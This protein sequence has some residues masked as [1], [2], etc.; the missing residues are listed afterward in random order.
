M[1]YCTVSTPRLKY[2]NGSEEGVR[3]ARGTHAGGEDVDGVERRL[4][5]LLVAEDEVDPVRQ[6]LGDGLRLQRLPVD[7]R[8]E[9]RVRRPRGQLHAV[10]AQPALTRAQVQT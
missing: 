5:G 1:Q 6:P 2:D 9:A 10:H 3:A 4:A 8:E 7:E